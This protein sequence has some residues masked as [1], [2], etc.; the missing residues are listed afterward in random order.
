[1]QLTGFTA[2]V[3]AI[4][5]ATSASATCTTSWGGSPCS[6]T[7]LACCMDIS[8]GVMEQNKKD[9]NWRYAWTR[10]NCNDCKA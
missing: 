8:Y 3:V 2:A 5:F 7:Q 9:E 4:F 10:A 1:M 6:G